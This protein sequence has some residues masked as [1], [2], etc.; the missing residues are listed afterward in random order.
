MY[1]MYPNVMKFIDDTLGSEGVKPWAE[2]AGG[3]WVRDFVEFRAFWEKVRVELF[4]HKKK[5]K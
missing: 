4:D 3:F 2:I 5:Q 1:I